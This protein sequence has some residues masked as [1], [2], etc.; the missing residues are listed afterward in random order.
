MSITGIVPG[1][2]VTV[3]FPVD[4]LPAHAIKFTPAAAGVTLAAFIKDGL[5]FRQFMISPGAEDQCK[6]IMYGVNI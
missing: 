6:I 4:A 2:L 1:N 5:Q 3:T